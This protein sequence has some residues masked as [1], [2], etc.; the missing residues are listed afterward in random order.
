MSI[1]AHFLI[2]RGEFRLDAAF[3]AAGSGLTAVFGASGAGKTSLLRA[4]A[5]LDRH[6]GSR[7]RVGDETWQ[8]ETAFVPPHRRAVGY[9]FQEPSLFP[10][11]DVRRNLAYGRKRQGG[12][13]A[14]PALEEIVELLGIEALLDR[15]AESLSGGEARRVAIARALAVG[16]RLLLMDEPLAGL[17]PARRE[18]VIPFLD[19]LRRESGVPV[20]YVSHDADEVARLADDVLLLADGRVQALGPVDQMLT[21][22]D[23]P[24]AT[25]P[26][27]ESVIPATVAG[28]D[29]RFGLNLLDAAGQRFRLA[30]PPRAPD[31]PLRLRIAARDVSITLSHQTDSSILN[32]FPAT[33]AELQPAGEGEIVVRLRLGDTALLARITRASAE[34]LGLAPESA[35]FVQIKSI[36]VLA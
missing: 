20:F 7:L 17:D 16:P 10:H 32:I 2:R 21:R 5:G 29:E 6:P 9:V 28:R 18:E 30:G 27:A 11:L 36:A 26:G 33:V 22:L 34:H 15:T 19:A 4:M 35:V 24:L 8:D 31:T 25:G 12:G 3:A 23:L 13:R 14:G 1:D